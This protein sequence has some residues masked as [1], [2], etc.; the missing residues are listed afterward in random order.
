[1]SEDEEAQ[2]RMCEA[3]GK[4]RATV[5]L[6]EFVDGE[7]VLR[8]LCDECYAEREGAPLVT[9]AALFQQILSAVAPELKDLA[10]KECPACGISYLQFRQQGTLGC[11][12]DYEEF[13]AALTK[14]MEEIHGATE[15]CGKVSPEAGERE[16]IQG[17]LRSLHRL[18]ERAIQREDYE[19]AAQLRDSIAE[20]ET[21][22]DES[23][24]A[25]Q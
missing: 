20:L 10:M 2:Q 5:H 9:P 16:A 11:P 8:L 25:E 6:T 19:L 15:H 14:L 17:R 7:P 1:V 18:Q 23:D 24:R 12:Q 22:A 4:R 13:S 21:R 3:C